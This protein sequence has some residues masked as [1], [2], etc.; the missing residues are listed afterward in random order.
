MKNICYIIGASVT[1]GMY[2]DKREGDYIIA[3]DAGLAALETLGI[4]ADLA[5]GDFDS[6]GT[7]PEFEN[8][9]CHPVEKD[10]T[11]TA[12]ALC[13][14][15]KLGFRTFVIYGG[16][17]GRLDHTMA[18]LQNCSG[19]AD[20]GAVIWLW[21]EDN[22]VCIFGDGDKLTFESEKEGIVSVFSPD[23][24][25]GVSIS[26]LKY[27]LSDACLTSSVPLGV[28]NEFIGERAEIKALDGVLMVM[29]NENAE[30]FVRRARG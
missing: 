3:A 15:M 23:R 2:I 26:G 13:E 25:T 14:G 30:M 27:K 18:N 9:I 28:S 1:C 21:G 29:W 10:D 6:L 7:I 5:V 19:A 24:T 20:H 4:E 16:L 11:D 17:G 12:L 22:A 8:K